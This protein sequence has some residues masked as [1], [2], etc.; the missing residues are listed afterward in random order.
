MIN[1]FVVINHKLKDNIFIPVS[2]AL[3][4]SNDMNCYCEFLEHVPNNEEK[5]LPFFGKLELG[6]PYSYKKGT[7]RVVANHIK[8]WL[9]YISDNFGQQH[10]KVII[11]TSRIGSFL[12]YNLFGT[13]DTIPA[14]IEKDP[15]D[16]STLLFIRKLDKLNT[17]KDSLSKTINDLQ[18]NNVND[19]DKHVLIHSISLNRIAKEIA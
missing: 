2:I 15:I 17:K 12:F 1:L 8:G 5:D 14:I 18:L 9:Y 6:F 3:S 19:I 13:Q 11:D 7:K 16:I 4:T 10:F